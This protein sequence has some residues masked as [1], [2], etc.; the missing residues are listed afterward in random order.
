ELRHRR[1][2]VTERHR[3]TR[4]IRR[5]DASSC[6]SRLY[7]DGV[8]RECVL[9][10]DGLAL[11]RQKGFRDQHEHVVRAVAE[12]DAIGVAAVLARER[13]LQLEIASSARCP[14]PNGFSLDASLML[15]LMPY[16]RSSSSSGLPGMYGASV[17]TPSGA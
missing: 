14:G 13:L 6:P 16:S 1:K 8:D 12:R 5:S 2:I 3:V 17:R 9:R 7:G 15:S 10:V 11:R 4:W